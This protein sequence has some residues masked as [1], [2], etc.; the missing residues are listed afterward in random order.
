MTPGQNILFTGSSGLL[1]TVRHGSLQRRNLMLPATTAWRFMPQAKTSGPFSTPPPSLPLRETTKTHARRGYE[2]NQHGQRGE[3]L[4][5]PEMP[6]CMRSP[7]WRAP[8]K[9]LEYSLSCAQGKAV[10]RLSVNDV[11]FTVPRYTLLDCSCYDGLF[12]DKTRC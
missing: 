1:G 4:R 7:C 5:R 12:K 10:S 8:A 2:Y 3:I 6:A 11:S 9:R